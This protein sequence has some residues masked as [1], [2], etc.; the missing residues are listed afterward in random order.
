MKEILFSKGRIALVD[1]DDF[2]WLSAHTWHFHSGYAGTNLKVANKKYKNALM[3][4]MILGLTD[5]KISVDHINGN[6]L[7]NRKINLRICTHAQNSRNQRMAKNNKSGYKGV[8]WRARDNLWRA[9]ICINGKQIDVG[10]SK[11]KEKAARLY[12]EAAKK[13]HGEFARLNFG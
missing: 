10:M 13:Y 8:T 5:S 3:H 7:D 11:C 1:D 6:G 4:R 9:T 2:I 12:D